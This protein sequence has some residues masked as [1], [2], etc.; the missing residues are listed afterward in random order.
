M[1]FG[2]FLLVTVGTSI[3]GA[4]C[5]FRRKA[6]KF[7]IIA[8]AMA[9]GAEVLSAVVVA[10]VVG[11]PLGFGKILFS[12]LPVVGG[13]LAIVAARQITA[14]NAVAEAPPPSVAAPM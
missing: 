1:G 11:V 13:I 7:I 12:A 9:I 5:L 6:A 10:L 2:L 4:V 8:A 14:A 3:A